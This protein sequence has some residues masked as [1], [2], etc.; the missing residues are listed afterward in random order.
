M[1]SSRDFADNLVQLSLPYNDHSMVFSVQYD[2]MV[3]QVWGFEPAKVCAVAWF[4]DLQNSSCGQLPPLCAD[5]VSTQESDEIASGT[6][7]G[8]YKFGNWSSW[9]DG[10]VGRIMGHHALNV[11][12]RFP[13]LSPVSMLGEVALTMKNETPSNS[14]WQAIGKCGFLSVFDAM[15]VSGKEVRSQRFHCG[16]NHALSDAPP[17]Y[18]CVRFTATDDS[19]GH[20]T[21][22]DVSVGNGG[23]YVGNNVR[24]FPLNLM[25]K[26]VVIV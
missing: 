20:S 6:L 8:S 9:S 16:F 23:Y 5:M 7:M 11:V 21:L 4:R 24:C 12:P 2:R 18:A 13:S 22:V 1:A 26:H 3:P 25:T 14:A 19:T 15:N 17:A 10:S